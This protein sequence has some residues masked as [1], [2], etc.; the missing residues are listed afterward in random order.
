MVGAGKTLPPREDNVQKASK[1]A[2]TRQRGTERDAEKRSDL[3]VRSQAWLPTLMLN[4]ESLLANAS[5]CD[6]QGGVA[7]YVADVVEQALLLPEDMAE[8][9]DMRRHGV[10][11][12]LKRYLATV[13]P[14]SFFPTYSLHFPLL[15]LVS[16]FG[17]PFKPLSGLRR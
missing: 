4:R 2:K 14:P 11:L 12:S 3:Q 6:F 9:R 13:C 1:Q 7:G 5:I 15:T 16:F 17:R 10:F 8:L